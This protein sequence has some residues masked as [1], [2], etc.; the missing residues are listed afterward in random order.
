MSSIDTLPDISQLEAR[1]AAL[2]T[3]RSK[4]PNTLPP[5]HFSVAA[6]IDLASDADTTLFI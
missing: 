2:E 4:V 6:F 3:S 1:I 5:D